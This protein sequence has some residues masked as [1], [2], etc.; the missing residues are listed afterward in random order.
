METGRG[1]LRDRELRAR[2]RH[3]PGLTFAPLSWAADQ[4]H[5]EVPSTWWVPHG[6][7]RETAAC[8]WPPK[9]STS[10]SASKTTVSFLKKLG[11]Y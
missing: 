7:G 5:P 6:K 1:S 10:F 2:A 9:A 8:E 3:S 11:V 4:L